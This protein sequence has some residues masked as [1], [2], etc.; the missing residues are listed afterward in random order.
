M[1][2]IIWW[3]CIKDKYWICGLDSVPLKS[4]L[5]KYIYVDFVL[6]FLYCESDSQWN[7]LPA[8]WKYPHDIRDW[9]QHTHCSHGAS[10]ILPIY[11]HID[12]HAYKCTVTTYNHCYHVHSEN[13]RYFL[14]LQRN[15]GHSEEEN[16]RTEAT[17]R[18]S[19]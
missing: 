17:F 6:L 8:E 15:S 9:K 3:A 10:Q 18:Q 4:Q 12:E 2:F 13:S 7:Y 5:F 14:H 19:L 16:H 11:V 1:L